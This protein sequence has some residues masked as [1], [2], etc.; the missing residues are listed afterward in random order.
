[1]TVKRW[2]GWMAN[3]CVL[4]VLAAV[5]LVACRG[6]GADAATLVIDHGGTFSGTWESDDAKTP[7]VRI[8]TSEPVVIGNSS[9]RGKGDLI[10]S[11]HDHANITVRNTS[12]VGQN[13]NVAGKCAGRFVSIERFSGVTIENCSMENTAG[14]YLLDYAGESQ[15]GAS[16]RAY[17]SESRSQYRR[18]AERW[19]RRLSKR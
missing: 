8:D 6:R 14:I 17:C 19:S 15:I 2:I 1:M 10:V 9:L 5:V 12:G 18:A 7:C 11:S 3:G 13:P 4:M 16:E